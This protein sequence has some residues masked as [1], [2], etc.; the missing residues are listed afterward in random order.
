MGKVK[1]RGER[2][3]ACKN[4]RESH[5]RAVLAR[6]VESLES[7]VLLSAYVGTQFGLTGTA[8]SYNNPTPATA[9]VADGD[10]ITGTSETTVSVSQSPGDVSISFSTLAIGSISLG[11][12]NIEQITATGQSSNTSN[13]LI[14]NGTGNAESF[15]VAGSVIQISGTS[16]PAGLTILYSGFSAVSINGGGGGD[17]FAVASDSV[18]TTISSGSGASTTVG[19]GSGNPLAGIAAA[20]D[21][22][23]GALTIADSTASAG[24]SG[25]LSASAVTGLGL[26]ASSGV[27]YS[28]L[29][30]LD[31]ELGPDGN[32]FSINDDSVPTTL[33]AGTGSD[34]LTLVQD[35]AQ[36]NIST[37][38]G[39]VSIQGTGATT[40]VATGGANTLL[41]GSGGTLSGIAGGTLHI[42]GSGSD[43]LSL[44]D[45]V[46]ASAHASAVVTSSDVSGLSDSDISYSGLGSLSIDLGTGG[47][48]L[49]VQS[50]HSGVSTAIS[51]AAG[52]TNSITVGN[53]GALSQISGAL[54]FAGNGSDHL[55]LDNSASLSGSGTLSNSSL[56]GLSTSPIN[57]GGIGSLQV[58]LG[59]NSLNISSTSASATSVNVPTGSNTVNVT[60]ISSPTTI[61]THGS[62][63]VNVGSTAP[64]LGGVVSGIAGLLSVSGVSGDSLVVDDS[65]STSSTNSISISSGA[66]A[67]RSSTI[68]YSGAINLAVHIGSGGGT[69]NISGDSTA[70]TTITD[71]GGNTIYNV[72]GDGGATSILAGNGNDTINVRGTG[73][74]GSTAIAT[75]TG[76]DAVNLGSNAPGSGGTLAPLAGSISV[77]GPASSSHT[78]MTLD[79]TGDLTAATFSISG[80]SIAG[81]GGAITYAHVSSL[82]VSLGAHGNIVSIS[83]TSAPTTLNS[84]SGNDVVTL[85]GNSSSTL[86]NTGLGNDQVNAQSIGAATTITAGSGTD[87]VTVG[88]STHNLAGIGA[89]LTI[90]G[91]SSTTLAVDDSANASTTTGTLAAGG[92]SGLDLGVGGSISYTGVG[93]VSVNL[94][95]GTNTFTVTGTSA[96]LN[97]VDSNSGHDTIA[98][99]ATGGSTTTNL[100]DAAITGSNAFN[101][102]TGRLGALLGGVNIQGV[103]HDALTL[104]DTANSAA[105]SGTVLAGS[106]TGFG[107]SGPGVSYSGVS[108]LTLNLAHNDTVAVASTSPTVTTSI[109][110]SGGTSHFNIQGI[111]GPTNI[112]TGAGTNDTFDI[113]STAPSAGGVV[114]GIASGELTLTGASNDSL[115]VD[116]GGDSS[117][118]TVVAGPP[119][120]SIGSN[121]VVQ[122]Y[123]GFSLVTI[124]PGSNASVVVHP[125]LNTLVLTAP[126]A[127]QVVVSVNAAASTVTIGGA[128]TSF[129]SYTNVTLT[130]QFFGGGYDPLVINGTTGADNISITGTSVAF[131]GGKTIH[132][133]GFDSL[134]VYGGGGNDTITDSLTG[135]MDSA[136]LVDGTLTNFASGTFVPGNGTTAFVVNGSNVPT[137][138]YGGGNSDSYTVNG[139]SAAL[140]INGGTGAGVFNVN[141]NAGSMV[142]NSGGGLNTFNI[143][144]NSA[145]LTVNGG[146][147]G[148]NVTVT[149]NSATLNLNGGNGTDS[150]AIT[151][152]TGPVNLQAGN[153]TTSI[154]VTAPA[155]AP[156]TITGGTSGSATLTYNGSPLSDTL[157][158]TSTSVQGLGPNNISFSHLAGLI[159][160]G[161]GGSDTFF[162]SGDSTPTTL[163]GGSSPDQFFVNSL[164]G[165]LAIN[166]VTASL[167]DIGSA[168]GPFAPDPAA[169]SVLGAVSG[170]VTIT[171][172]GSD[173][174]NLDD[175]G[176]ANPATASL[177]AGGFSQ[178]PLSVVYSHLGTLN[179]T[180]GSGGNT[181][182]V[183]GS[184][185]GATTN[186]NTGAG[187]DKA[188]VQGTGGTTNINTG[189][190]SNTL[191]VGSTAGSLPAVPGTLNNIVGPLSFTDNVTDSL[192][193]DDSGGSTP[194]TGALNPLSL[195]LTGVGLISWT[196]VTSLGVNLGGGNNTLTITNTGV[197]T[198]T[199]VTNAGTGSD[200]ITLVADSSP[201]TIVTSAGSSSVYVQSTA[202]DTS[203]APA[204]GGT[205]AV[206][207]GSTAA[208]GNST[209][210]ILDHIQGK[211]TVNVGV[212]GS[213]SLD[214]TGSAGAKTD[215]KLTSSAITG[216]GMGTSGILYSGIA[217]LNINLGSGA[218]TFTIASTGAATTNLTSAATTNGDTINVLN[219]SGATNITTGGGNDVVNVQA[220]GA[221]GITS[222]NTAGGSDVVNLGSAAP[223]TGGFVDS[224]KGAISITGS[225]TL[226]VNVDDTG[227]TISK[228]DGVLTSGSLLGLGTGGITYSNVSLLNINLGAQGN[229]FTIRS[230]NAS[231]TTNL[232]SGAGNDTVYVQSTAGAT[233]IDTG[234]GTNTLNVGSLDS[235]S[236][237]EPNV[238]SVLDNIH[239]TLS[240]T[241]HSSDTLNLDDAGSTST[242]NG[243]LTPTAVTGLSPAPI[244]Y[245]GIATLNV[246]LGSGVNVFT[247]F[248]TGAATTNLTS[249]ATINPLTVNVQNDS[250]TTN[251]TTGGA[252]DTVNIQRTGGATTVTNPGGIDTDN[253]GSNAPA[254]GGV[255]DNLADPITINGN[256]ADNLN[257]DDTGSTASKTD[258]VLTSASLTGLGTAGVTYHG[259]GVMDINLGSGGDTFVVQNTGATTTNITTHSTAG[260]APESITVQNDSGTTN[261]ATGNGT[262]QVNIR[263]TGVL[264]STTVTAG[265]GSNTFNLGSRAPATG[266]SLD[267]LQGAI[268]LTG[269][270]SQTVANLDDTGT[271][272]ANKTGQ[273]NATSITGLGTGGVTYTGIGVLNISLGNHSN[274]FTIAATSGSTT[275]TIT[276]GTGGDTFYVQSTA[277]GPSTTID[278]GSGTNFVDV[279]S[280]APSHGNVNGIQGPLIVNGGGGDTLTVDDSASTTAKTGTLTNSAVTGLGMGSAGVAYHAI[281]TLNIEL[282]SGADTMNVRS[283]ASSATTTIDT[284]PGANV[285]NL[286][287]NSPATAGIL[288]GLAGPLIV[289]GHGSD[290]LNLDDTGSATAKTGTLTSSSITGLAT[291]G[292][293]YSGVSSLNIH[294]GA[295]GDTL[296]V[297]STSAAATT[298]ITTA[299]GAN[300]IDVGSNDTPTG[301]QPATGSVLAAIAGAL[302][303]TG[304]GSDILNVDDV[305]NTAGNTGQLT[306]TSITGL[307]PGAIGY[308][309]VAKLTVNLGSGA[310]TLTVLSTDHAT[311]NINSGAGNDAITVQSD[312]GP[313]NI[314][315]GPGNDVVNVLATSAATSINTGGSGADTINVGSNAPT[316]TGGTLA[317]VQGVVTVTGDGSDT[318]NADDSGVSTGITLSVSG[319]VVSASNANIDYGGLSHLNINLGGG[320]NTISVTGTSA[321]AG[322]SITAGN[323]NDTFTVV[324]S[325][326]TPTAGLLTLAG[327]I[328]LSPGLGTNSLTVNDSIDPV[329]RTVGVTG[330]TITGLGGPINYVN[331]QNLTLLLGTASGNAVNVTGPLPLNTTIQNGSTTGGTATVTYTGDFTGN[332]T[333]VNFANGSMSVGGNFLGNLTATA[334]GSI[335]IGGS[336]DTGMI[337]VGAINTIWAPHLTS[338]ASNNGVVLQVTQGG[339]LRQIS[340][341]IPAAGGGAL[342]SYYTA[343]PSTVTFAVAYDGASLSTAPQAAIRV[344]NASPQVRFDLL[345]SSPVGTNFDLSRVD[346]AN[347]AAADLR[348]VTVE[349]DVLATISNPE[350]SLLALTVGSVGGVYLPADNLASLATWG[351][352]PAGV[353]RTTG[354]EGIAFATLTDTSKVVHTA[355]SLSSE[356]VEPTLLQPLAINPSTKK[357]YEA[358]NLPTETLRVIFNTTN[359]VGL[360]VDGTQG[361]DDSSG[362]NPTTN[363]GDFEEHGIQF[364]DEAASASLPTN[365]SITA[366]STFA[367]DTSSNHRS[368]VTQLSFVGDGA[369][370]NSTT[371]IQNITSTGLLGDLTLQGDSRGASSNLLTNL[372][373]PGV[374]G[375][376]ELEGGTITG[377]F[378]TTG[379]RIDP[380]TGATS[381]VSADIGST[382]ISS[383]K[384][385]GVTY[386]HANIAAG[387][388]L[389]SRGNLT[390]SLTA[391]STIAGVIGVQG[392]IGVGVVSGTTLTR[393]GG[394][395]AAGLASTAD[396]V[397][398]GNIF[399]DVNISGTFAGRITAEGT[400]VSGLSSSQTGILGNVT[401][402]TFS[403]TGAVISGGMIS[404]SAQGT[405]INIT[406]SFSGFLA[407]INA[408]NLNSKSKTSSSRTFANQT[409]NNAAAITRIWSGVPNLDTFNSSTGSLIGLTQ[410][411][412][413]M[414]KLTVSGSTLTGT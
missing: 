203:V 319:T 71:A 168:D 186:I 373:A 231:T 318:L 391:S 315:T 12:N 378:Q 273:L 287:S 217:T 69:A 252:A 383:G 246:H 37:G 209:P 411:V 83:G 286:G 346:T 353:I 250:G 260:S 395:T 202:A 256:G 175:S 270:G 63:T 22:T 87:V 364:T 218:D 1:A 212:N 323:G 98:V 310:D 324:P 136:T 167:I 245:A 335:T 181:L 220:T 11:Y 283:T 191:A 350:A 234:A 128:T 267:N 337:T 24:Q 379:V 188:Y 184:P 348:N 271:A 263:S 201:T 15:L 126:I 308:G 8:L 76:V 394:I 232:N 66:V 389:V 153:G 254:T 362:A 90:S 27:Q 372:T 139:N 85:T 81:P 313:T 94:G 111:G 278:T 49:T 296:A 366:F 410:L 32:T 227:A 109:V 123:S 80:S 57:Y 392:N 2:L 183:T 95:S 116:D 293:T 103:S 333:L 91:Q 398:L 3:R 62:A 385:T 314:N 300:T 163:N 93:A 180:M 5:R 34:D 141:G 298:N 135:V 187:N 360:F 381:A 367:S 344:A 277:A 120:I 10:S 4:S 325:T 253:L 138:I 171:G 297:Q 176:N 262:E 43:A 36:T 89:A 330:S 239:G 26:G 51:S 412:S 347:G 219:D 46:D 345:L 414:N 117:P 41:V 53:I 110:T 341:G 158:I 294:L 189:G 257:L 82:L 334:L 233:N 301:A 204:S 400:A 199:T 328:T 264:S 156:V 67:I 50:T 122:N 255:L 241:G 160:N 56:S 127:T 206:F 172:A 190:G 59:A 193:I 403:S 289:V 137:T 393:F 259:V 342:S 213:L 92:V 237:Y 244:D 18:P 173:V 104:S 299:G 407:A 382:I 355:A 19:D 292:I 115:T 45:S 52:A 349:G 251:I 100:V 207:V 72:S 311:T 215:G 97:T 332:L 7:R 357:Y 205:V 386:L 142:L 152:T 248:N 121:T 326:N 150:F 107:G 208:P 321:T 390:A 272:V 35:H 281:H 48:G 268:V 249:S 322:T 40:T 388:R 88:A 309:G 106:V 361:N 198:P 78:G 143:H 340:A 225:G 20:L 284:G 223:A 331:F 230:T 221:G 64:A 317:G 387:A 376:I 65:G 147:T 165:Q 174:L 54:S 356:S 154:S 380:V 101:V 384:V 124:I 151:N 105:V 129:A 146:G 114:S 210:G 113:G 303:F 279:S 70:S 274:T 266:G 336:L 265:S 21:V 338:A 6:A 285:V 316:I 377:T 329:V 304:D 229:I 47:D 359:T 276:G 9:T 75:G 42:A 238:S 343:V 307:S 131:L 164:A 68:D 73:A 365:Q 397:A 302:N 25:A 149:S 216:L 363:N 295:G 39:T 125:T 269:N 312:S 99:Q 247:I 33:N 28:G 44:I 13:T 177:G 108:T 161:N 406:S 23:G 196:A 86:I 144:G 192:V 224:L 112:N 61:T 282:G 140:T 148:D 155:A 226:A 14:V 306:S 375:N 258:G 228:T 399:G 200:A 371:V 290:T 413:E 351:N 240:I 134:W 169:G 374:F 339:S 352:L 162:V 84:G 182:T 368:W 242:K 280:A 291:A 96:A 197:S 409:G 396:I 320:N 29:S 235:S 157:T 55:T 30:G 179:L 102:G 288:D 243:Q 222:I 132:Y 370:V 74:G 38:S 130:G 185:L 133:S 31:V 358:V 77:S 118:G 214:D 16:F 211:L 119:S 327:P 236:A 79:D 159:V 402:S 145:M 17:T 408:I 275:T 60:G 195:N 166:T 369:S 354:I 401:I 261:I 178:G 305:G 170:T 194:R 404:D 405:T 58:N